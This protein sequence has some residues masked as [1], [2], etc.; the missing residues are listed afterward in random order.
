[1][2]GNDLPPDT[3][4]SRRETGVGVDA[5]GSEAQI[6]DRLQWSTLVAARDVHR[7]LGVGLDIGRATH[8]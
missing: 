5:L 4:D 1:M 6:V 3:A 8:R 2:A 7:R